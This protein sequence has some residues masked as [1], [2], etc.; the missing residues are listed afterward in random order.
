MH[1]KYDFSNAELIVPPKDPNKTRIC[2]RIDTKT[3]NW[4]RQRVREAGGGNY[5]TMINNALKE[6]IDRHNI[7]N[8]LIL[9]GLIETTGTVSGT[10]TLS[11]GNVLTAS[12]WD[13]LVHQEYIMEINKSYLALKKESDERKRYPLAA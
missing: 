12:T 3:L 6:F 9:T 5:Q 1:K 13:S 10:V 7:K 2:I 11:T 4:F 8:E